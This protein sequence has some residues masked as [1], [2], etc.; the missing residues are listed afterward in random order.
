MPD[1]KSRASTS[2]TLS[3]RV[4]ASSA[5]PAPDHAAADDDDVELLAA[6]PLPGLFPLVEIQQCMPVARRGDRVAHA[7]HSSCYSSVGR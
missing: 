7:K 2:A 5:A 6:E 3:P 4:A 1:A